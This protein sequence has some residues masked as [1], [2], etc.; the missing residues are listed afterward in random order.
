MARRTRAEGQLASG[1]G[2][3]DELELGGPEPAGGGWGD[4]KTK[5]AAKRG[6]C[7]SRFSS[8]PRPRLLLFPP[9]RRTFLLGAHRQST[10]S[11]GARLGSAWREQEV[12]RQWGRPRPRQ[13]VPISSAMASSGQPSTFLP[14]RPRSRH[15]PA[16]DAAEA[17]RK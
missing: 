14:P 15:C 7:L 13:L 17:G 16:D 4:K 8:P 12:A 5:R 6:A 11:L 3:S 10:D 9:T 1:A 2:Q